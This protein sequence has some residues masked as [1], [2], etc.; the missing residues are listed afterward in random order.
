MRR[1][2][3]RIIFQP[4]DTLLTMSEIA[5]SPLQK[6]DV[7]NDEYIADRELTPYTLKP[8]FSVTD[9]DSVVTGGDHASEL[10]NVVWTVSARK[11]NAAP[12]FGTDYTI[13]PVTHALTLAFNLDPDTSGYV[14][15]DA[16]YVDARRGDIIKCH[17]EKQLL[18]VSATDW[19]TELV[20]E[21]P[22]R[23]DLYPWKDRGT[24]GLSVQLM[25]GA[26]Q[27]P[28]A[29]CTYQWQIF[30]SDAW[31]AVDVQK[32][33]WC[34]GGAD[35]K[36]LQVEQQ[37]VQRALIR[38]CAWPT[39]RSAEMRVLAF[40]LRRHYGQYDD[41]LDILEGEYVFPQTTRA[42]AEA[43]V[44]NRNGGRI[45]SPTDYF[46]MEILYSRDGTA[47]FHV[48]HG[49]V[50]EVPR[51]MFPVDATMVHQFS[52]IT[53]EKSALIPLMIDGEVMTVDGSIAVGQF[54]IIERD[55]DV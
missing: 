55:L 40:L 12:V 5:G 22:S 54:P 14:R 10:V 27:I 17:W 19:K 23:M 6:Y 49:P 50:G 39:G 2:D 11:N 45:P 28:D 51:S 13:D 3:G 8:V 30:E 25:N 4:L 21:W 20:T 26:S 42:V 1:K 46:D 32:D 44:V 16:D 38:C 43:Y 34:R 36:T 29:E 47:W 7:V 41:D 52:W 33:Y 18:C 37:Y 9:K 15:F 35:T 31:R 53:R 24:F 48:A